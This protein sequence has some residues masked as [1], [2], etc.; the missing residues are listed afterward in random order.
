MLQCVM[1]VLIGGFRRKLLKKDG[2]VLIW[3]GEATDEPARED[4]RPT[5]VGKLG[6]YQKDW[7][8]A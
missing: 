1:V 3:W 7:V 5:K 4:A 8:F 6:H 2:S